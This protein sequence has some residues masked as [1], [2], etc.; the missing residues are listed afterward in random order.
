M[1]KNFNKA[2]G[3]VIAALSM[4]MISLPASAWVPGEPPTQNQADA[5]QI[6]SAATGNK[7]IEAKFD[8][9]KLLLRAREIQYHKAKG[10]LRILV[11]FNDLSSEG[12][13]I[14]IRNTDTLKPVLYDNQL[15]SMPFVGLAEGKACDRQRWGFCQS[16]AIRL[17]SDNPIFFVMKFDGSNLVSTEAASISIPIGY[18][19]LRDGNRF[20][21]DNA[22]IS[23]TITFRDLAIKEY[24]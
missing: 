17:T 20:F 8:N 14:T 18:S 21:K 24:E 12:R 22:F 23:D 13:M 16:V 15:N 10:E 2:F 7:D 6:D 3:S 19:F 1:M 4:W 11:E 5:D 9:H